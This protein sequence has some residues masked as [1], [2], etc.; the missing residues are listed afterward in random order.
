MEYFSVKVP[1]HSRND[2][3][4]KDRKGEGDGGRGRVRGEGE[5]GEASE[6]YQFL[7]VAR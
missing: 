6:N 1:F 4:I 2:L 7:K 5:G 3:D